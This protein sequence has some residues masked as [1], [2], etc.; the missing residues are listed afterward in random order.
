MLY[1]DKCVV[2]DAFL[3]QVSTTIRNKIIANPY[4]KTVTERGSR[5]KLTVLI[6][7]VRRKFEYVHTDV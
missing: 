2:I 5:H 4:N 6:M 7:F 3:Q 1:D